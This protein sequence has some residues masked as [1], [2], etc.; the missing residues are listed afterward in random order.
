MSRPDNNNI[1]VITV[2]KK[3]SDGDIKDQ[4]GKLWPDSGDCQI[5]NTSTD[6]ILPNGKYL[7]RFRKA[8]ISEKLC[9]IGL[10]QYLEVGFH[11]S[12]NRGNAAGRYG[13][14]DNVSKTKELEKKFREFNLASDSIYETDSHEVNSGI[15]GFMDSANWRHPCRQTMFTKKHFQKYT[16]GLPFIRDI[17]RCYKELRPLEHQTQLTE[18]Q[19]SSYHITDT[20]FS[21]ITVNAN[22]QTGLHK[23]SGDF[24]KGFGNLVI[25]EKGEYTGGYTLFPQYGVGFDC[26]MTDFLAMD[27]HQWHCN[28]P[29]VKKDH[30]AV[31][32]SF[33]CYLRNRMHQCP[34][35]DKILPAQGNLTSKQKIERF[36]TFTGKVGDY[37]ATPVREELGTGAFGH[38][39]YQITG[40]KYSVRYYN[41]QY[42][43][44]DLDTQK[45]EYS[46]T[47]AFYN[48][49]TKYNT[50]H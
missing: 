25:T 14:S 20:A 28:T 37:S 43:I 9:Q 48:F 29:I 6:V 10:D 26:R 24:T 21:T 12:N 41:K 18:A 47:I 33:V 44:T 7:A 27:V 31:R 3:M 5:I 13:P 15:M 35:L 16:E 50:N 8:M 2:T 19:K 32:L 30:D 39:W 17:D 36:V 42:T 34:M 4:A 45:K 46:L 49:M 40:P 1:N 22:F 11:K 38:K 23:D